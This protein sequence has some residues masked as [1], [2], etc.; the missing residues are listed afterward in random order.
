MDGKTFNGW[1]GDTNKTWRIEE[2]AFVGGSLEKKVPNNEFLKTRRTFTNFVLNAKFKLLG[3]N[4]FVNGGIQI[5]STEVPPHEMRGYQCDIGDGWWGAIYDEM[6]RNKVLI[7]PKAE[8]VTRAVKRFDWNEYT[9]RAEGKRIQTW[10]NGVQMVDYTETD[11]S[12]P[13]H[14]MIGLQVHGGGAAEIRYKEITI[15]ELP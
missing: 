14:G 13:Q 10:I 11:E 7:K 2:G 3:T 9:I 8:D 6:R 4:G 5:R 15:E 12:L 1:F